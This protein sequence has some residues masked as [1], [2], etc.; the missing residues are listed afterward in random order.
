[1]QS[2]KKIQEW[3]QMQVPLCRE[4][5]FCTNANFG[6]QMYYESLETFQLYVIEQETP[7]GWKISFSNV[8]ID[9]K[10]IIVHKS[11]G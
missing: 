10:C 1:M 11:Q 9:Y 2:L 6:T 4:N 3:A 7:R 8:K 5:H